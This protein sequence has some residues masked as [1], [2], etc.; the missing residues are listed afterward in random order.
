MKQRSKFLQIKF[1]LSAAEMAESARM[2]LG[3]I[4]A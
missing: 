4:N 2:P 3:A 1:F